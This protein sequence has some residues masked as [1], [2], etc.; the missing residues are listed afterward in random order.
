MAVLEEESKWV[1]RMI[2]V[3][4]IS[5]LKQH[6]R[7]P[8]PYLAAIQ[9]CVSKLLTCCNHDTLW[10]YKLFD[11]SLSSYRSRS[12]IEQNVGKW[13]AHVR[14]DSTSETQKSFISAL[15]CLANTSQADC[16]LGSSHGRVESIARSMQEL[17]FDYV[18]EPLIFDNIMNSTS[19]NINK[20]Y[21]KKNSNLVVLFS[22]LPWTKVDF[23]EFIKDECSSVSCEGLLKSF[24]GKFKSVNES[25]GSRDIHVCWVDI[26]PIVSVSVSSQGCR[27]DHEI[28]EQAVLDVFRRMG[29]GFASVDTVILGSKLVPFSLI[30]PTIAY[31]SVNLTQRS[32]SAEVILELEDI[33]GNALFCKAC[34]VQWNALDQSNKNQDLLT[35]DYP[36]IEYSGKKLSSGYMRIHVSEVFHKD[37]CPELKRFVSSRLFLSG[38]SGKKKRD[39]TGNNHKR[40]GV[41]RRP[42]KEEINKNLI[43]DKALRKVSEEDMNKG[44]S[45]DEVLRKASTEEMNRDLIGDEVLRRLQHQDGEFKC[46]K[47]AWQ[48]LLVFLSRENCMG[49][50]NISDGENHSFGAILQ[51]FTVHAAILHVLDTNVL[52]TPCIYSRDSDVE[53][54]CSVQACTKSCE[55]EEQTNPDLEGQDLAKAHETQGSSEL[56]V[57]L[58]YTQS[59]LFEQDAVSSTVDSSCPKQFRSSKSLANR[60]DRDYISAKGGL[61][62]HCNTWDSFYLAIINNICKKE[63]NTDASMRLETRYFKASH[64]QSKILRFLSRWMKKMSKKLDASHGF[65]LEL[66]PSQL[67]AQLVDGNKTTLGLVLEKTSQLALECQQH[68]P[69]SA[70]SPFVPNA[71]LS[72]EAGGCD[73]TFVDS[74]HAETFIESLDGKIQHELCNKEVDLRAIAKRLTDMLIQHIEAQLKGGH[75]LSINGDAKTENSIKPPVYIEVMK[76][77]LKKPKELA[78]KYKDCLLPLSSQQVD[79][80]V[81]SSVYTSEEKV[82][83][84]ELQVLF[85]MEILASKVSRSIEEHVK[86]RLIK[87]IC[88]LLENIQFNLPG[89]IFDGES[90]IEF[91]DRVIK[92]RYRGC[93]EEVIDK[94]Y[95]CME[96]C[97]RDESVDKLS[98]MSSQDKECDMH[99]KEDEAS[100]QNELMVTNSE[101]GGSSGQ[102]KESHIQ[103]SLT[104]DE[105]HPKKLPGDHKVSRINDDYQ[106]KLKKAQAKR[107]RA[108]RFAHF[109]SKARDLQRVWAPKQPSHIIKKQSKTHVN[110]LK[111]RNKIGEG[112][113]VY[114][115]PINPSKLR[116]YGDGKAVA[117]ARKQIKSA[118]DVVHETPYP[119]S[120]VR[121]FVTEH[122]GDIV[123]ET[124]YPIS[125]I[126][127]HDTGLR[128]MAAGHPNSRTTS[129]HVMPGMEMKPGSISRALFEKSEALQTYDLTSCDMS[130]FGLMETFNSQS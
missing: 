47:P 80:S 123:N 74:H 115:T 18:W 69:I 73:P 33:D 71:S 125:K 61:Y 105:Q 106:N 82:R 53:G 60:K 29:W 50:V 42:C 117:A 76:L 81:N 78:I 66:N 37:K 1:Q 93:L 7:N 111:K 56:K 122:T 20:N 88:K 112:D 90:L 55:S 121:D 86:D 118:V 12:M 46:G 70:A 9:H 113:V 28:S 36:A 114:E 77:I 57:G 17:I 54:D 2:V 38:F 10:A 15:K 31:P 24:S 100:S 108:W 51:P 85:R 99:R 43:G 107:E 63:S 89:G 23:A 75:S 102:I 30:W 83:E 5:D 95:E 130:G 92:S 98:S 14:F 3:V 127:H 13:A 16:P 109:T 104:G 21:F 6:T 62:L 34:E 35:M 97:S 68:C 96:F 39:K 91:A 67:K 87:E 59:M 22:A 84:H 41:E 8:K 64:S 25:F 26:A 129:Q 119:L 11:S 110:L 40:N 103:M 124:P 79:D 19:K 120:K 4:D 45:G 27:R 101:E 52:I 126:Q 48:L 65:K 116:K 58:A 49:L 72:T 94:I 32:S 128:A 44:L